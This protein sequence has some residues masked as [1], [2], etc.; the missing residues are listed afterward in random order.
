MLSVTCKTYVM[1]AFT[2]NVIMVSVFMLKFIMLSVIMLSVVAPNLIVNTGPKQLFGYL[3]LEFL[4]QEQTYTKIRHNCPLDGGTSQ[5]RPDSQPNDSHQSD[6]KDN[7]T[8]AI[9]Y[10]KQQL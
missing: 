6:T 2:L 5:W 8:K 4:L 7:N 1:S 3:P 9:V 10:Y